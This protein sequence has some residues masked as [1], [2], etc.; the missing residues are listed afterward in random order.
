MSGVSPGKKVLCRGAGSPLADGTPSWPAAAACPRPR[1]RLQG[2]GQQE[3]LLIHQTAME[4]LVPGTGSAAGNTQKSLTAR[5]GDR[6]LSCLTGRLLAE[7]Q[8][9]SRRPAPNRA[10]LRQARGKPRS[11]L[12]GSL[13][14]TDMPRGIYPISFSSS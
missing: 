6:L 4:T 10:A 7:A 1:R 12:F 11:S 9:Q 2:W 8:S 5:E 13:R 14:A 3:G